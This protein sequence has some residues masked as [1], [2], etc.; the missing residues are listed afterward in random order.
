[1]NI[2]QA[3]TSFPEVAER[4]NEI[5]NLVFECIDELEEE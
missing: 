2:N 1:M 3:T 4:N 5:W